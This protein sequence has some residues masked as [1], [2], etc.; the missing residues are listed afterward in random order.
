MKLYNPIMITARLLPGIQIGNG[1]ISIE[2][3][4]RA[5]DEGRTRYQYHIDIFTG[6][7]QEPI[8]YSNDDIQSGCQGG[9]LLEGLSS[10]LSFLGAA[11]ESY[12]YEQRTGYESDNADLFPSEIVLWANEN[13]NELSMLSCESDESKSVLIEE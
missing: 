3:S 9:N 13:F 12:D 11:A 8:E 10:L 1:T 6:M 4:K 5:G 7:A 2:Y